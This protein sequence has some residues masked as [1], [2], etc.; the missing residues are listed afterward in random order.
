MAPPTFAV[1]R[2]RQQLVDQPLISFATRIREEGVNLRDRG[3]Q[4]EQVETQAAD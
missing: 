4:A 1:M 2:R 3:W